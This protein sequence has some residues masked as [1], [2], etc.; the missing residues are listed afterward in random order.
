VFSSTYTWV[1]LKLVI[2]SH[3]NPASLVKKLSDRK[4]ELATYFLKK[5]L[6]EHSSSRIVSRG[7]A[8]D[9][10]KIVGI[11]QLFM[12]HSHNCVLGN[13][14]RGCNP[15]HFSPRFHFHTMQHPFLQIRATHSLGRSGSIQRLH[16]LYD[17]DKSC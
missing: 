3:V 13:S 8:L 11:Q 14:L 6:D 5:L 2:L 12:K 9:Q 10:F 4:C 15:P 1:L 16:C 7:K 17:A